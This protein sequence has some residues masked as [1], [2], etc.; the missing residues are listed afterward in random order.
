M[1]TIEL[2]I[3]IYCSEC[4]YN[5]SGS[6]AVISNTQINIEPCPNCMQNEYN[7]GREEAENN[8]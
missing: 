6:S 4:G 7:K 8:Q 1:P 2:D 5:L 3:N